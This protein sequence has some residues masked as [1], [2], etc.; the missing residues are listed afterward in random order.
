MKTK[1]KKMVKTIGWK[2]TT[3]AVSGTHKLVELAFNNDPLEFL[4]IFNDLDVVHSEA[5][6]NWILYRYKKYENLMVYDKKNEIVYLNYYVILSFLEDGF[7]LNYEEIQDITKEWL[8]ETYNLRGVT[9]RRMR[10]GSLRM[11]GE[12]YNLRGVTA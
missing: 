12:T 7:G 10:R 1:L 9:A 8:G 6:L 2:N 11:L 4:N 5:N 3:N